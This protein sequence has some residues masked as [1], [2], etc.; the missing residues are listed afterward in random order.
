MP[1]GSI[2]VMT[3]VNCFCATIFAAAAMGV[4]SSFGLVA[5]SSS[6]CPANEMGAY[7]VCEI[8]Q[9]LKSVISFIL[10]GVMCCYLQRSSCCDWISAGVDD[11][12]AEKVQLSAFLI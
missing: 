4:L 5:H 11:V 7:S 8:W 3:L 2:N 12:E 1:M 10:G 9:D 6:Y